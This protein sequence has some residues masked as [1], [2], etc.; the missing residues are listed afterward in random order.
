MEYVKKDLG[1]FNLHMI[2][3]EKF[4]TITMKIVF[5]TPIIKEEITKRLVVGDLLLQSSKNYPSKQDLIIKAEDLYAC[6]LSS[7]NAR[8]GNYILTSFNMQMLQDKYTEEGNMD[9]SFAFLSDIIF[10]PDIK[11]KSFKREKLDIVKTNVGV[12]LDSIKE[13]PAGYSMMRMFEEY[14]SNSPISYRMMG[15]KE[16]LNKIN[17]KNLYDTYFHMLNNDYIDI[18]VTGDFEFNEM[19]ALIKKYFKFKSIKKK[20]KSYFLPV[21]KPRRKKKTVKEEINNNQSKLAIAASIAKLTPYERNY[22]LMLMNIIFGGSVESKLFREVREENSL[23]Y[24]IKSFANRLDSTMVISAGIDRVNFDKTL[25]LI[26]KDL[27]DM[28]KGKFKDADINKAKEFCYTLLEELEE[29][30]YRLIS[31]YLVRELLKLDPLEERFKKI[32]K[33]T[34]KEIVKVAKKINIDTVFLLEGVDY[35]E[36]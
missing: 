15:Y 11:N 34:K 22:P 27:S 5:H 18:F 19:L 20:K 30:E 23:C 3:T 31:E 13:N 21:H 2:K 17:E 26:T 1:S 6:E 29:D 32:S 9:S 4:K 36:D 28:K 14:D 12:I 7:N 33:I 35:E 24:T 10:N 16:D 8:L 25:E